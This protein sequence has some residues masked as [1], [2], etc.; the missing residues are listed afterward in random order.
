MDLHLRLELK[1][2]QFRNLQCTSQEF[3]VTLSGCNSGFP[4]ITPNPQYAIRS[5]GVV[6]ERLHVDVDFDS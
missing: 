1:A 6:G 4:T 2:D 5:A 3:Q